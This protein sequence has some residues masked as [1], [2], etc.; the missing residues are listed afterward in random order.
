MDLF[1]KNVD[2]K[3][4]AHHAF[5]EYHSLGTIKVERLE[6][7]IILKVLEISKPKALGT[8]NYTSVYA[9]SVLIHR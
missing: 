3:F 9:S 1:N 8:I 7:Q 6:S 4:N 5:L 2:I